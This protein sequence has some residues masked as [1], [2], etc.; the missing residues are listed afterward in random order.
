MVYEVYNL[1]TGAILGSFDTYEEADEFAEDNDGI[2]LALDKD[3]AYIRR[4][5]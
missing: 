3:G 1:D 2:R 4:P 5:K